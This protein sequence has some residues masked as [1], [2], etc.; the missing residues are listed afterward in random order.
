MNRLR[1][2]SD[3]KIGLNNCEQLIMHPKLSKYFTEA[4]QLSQCLKALKRLKWRGCQK[5]SPKYDASQRKKMREKKK[6]LLMT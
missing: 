2:V 6:D 1:M 5:S 3:A 4:Y